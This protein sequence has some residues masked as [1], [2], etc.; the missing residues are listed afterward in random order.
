MRLLFCQWGLICGRAGSL[1]ITKVDSL[2]NH[3]QRG[4]EHVQL[5]D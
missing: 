4:D 5:L 1:A 2:K 3:D